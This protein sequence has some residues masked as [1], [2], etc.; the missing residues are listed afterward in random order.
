MPRLRKKTE[1][2]DFITKELNPTLN[3]LL[4]KLSDVSE[5]TLKQLVIG[6]ED[7]RSE[8]W[9]LGK[10]SIDLLDFKKSVLELYRIR[11]TILESHIDLNDKEEIVEVI[12]FLI[13]KT[14]NFGSGI[15]KLGDGY[16]WYNKEPDKQKKGERF[17]INL[18]DLFKPS[19]EKTK[20]DQST[21]LKKRKEEL[22]HKKIEREPEPTA[23]PKPIIDLNAI[24]DSI[25]PSVP[26]IKKLVPIIGLIALYL[27]LAQETSIKEDTNVVDTSLGL[28]NK[29]KDIMNDLVNSFDLS[30]RLE[31]A[32]TII[33]LVVI[34]SGYKYWLLN[35]RVIR[36]NSSLVEKI[37]FVIILL[38]IIRHV[39]IDSPIGKFVDWGLFLGVLYLILAGTWL[40]AEWV[41]SLDLRSDLYC[42]GLRIVGIVLMIIG[43]LLF[44]SSA[45]V[46][47]FTNV[48]L[49]FN[50]VY[51]IASVC[52]MALGAFCEYRSLRRYPAVHVW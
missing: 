18:G 13:K 12:D 28:I 10:K 32:K 36:Q 4:G 39:K 5:G 51:W 29:L 47:T 22:L 45:L 38:I 16:D 3:E 19:K 46:L 25:K 24:W 14:E 31:V 33:L 42:W 48:K 8:L 7:W 34:W 52:L 44:T 35:I 23:P 17:K 40:A 50:N 49:V 21:E 43:A 1:F 2:H 41:N 15:F 6:L 9:G 30:N 37:V 11:E 26:S 20:L 27:V